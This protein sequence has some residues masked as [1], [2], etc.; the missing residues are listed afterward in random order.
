MADPFGE[1]PTPASHLPPVPTAW[2]PK[3]VGP[4]RLCRVRNDMFVWL[5]SGG[6]KP[7]GAGAGMGMIIVHQLCLQGKIS[8]PPLFRTLL[9]YPLHS[10]PICPSHVIF[11]FPSAIL[12]TQC[13]FPTCLFFWLLHIGW[14]VKFFPSD[15]EVSGLTITLEKLKCL[16]NTQ[17]LEGKR[18][19][20]Y[21]ITFF[22][23]DGEES[24]VVQNAQKWVSS[25]G[26]DS[27]PIPVPCVIS[28][29]CLISL[30]LLAYLLLLC[31]AFLSRSLTFLSVE[32]VSSLGQAPSNLK[33]TC[34]S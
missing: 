14:N 21:T 29:Q 34:I 24:L 33:S 20:K 5:Y 19:R 11:V 16:I 32:M 12:F 18:K 13:F 3:V 17:L 27:L 30:S 26:L 10:A 7:W 9:P 25:R 8:S 15:L 1:V 22:L 28:S 4:S 6:Q 31:L 2:L 23:F